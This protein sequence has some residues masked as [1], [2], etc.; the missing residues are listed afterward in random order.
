[1]R[2]QFKVRHPRLQPLH[3]EA[4]AL[5][6]RLGRV[7]FE[8]V[9]RAANSEADRL[10]NAAMDGARSPRQAPAGG[11]ARGVIAIGVDIESNSNGSANCSNATARASSNASS[12]PAKRRTACAD[13]I[14]R[15]TLPP[16]SPRRRAAMKAPGDRA[17][18]RRSLAQHRGRA[19]RRP[20]AAPA[21]RRGRTALR[22]AGRSRRAG[23]D[24]PLR[25]YRAGAGAAPRP[26]TSTPVV[27]RGPRTTTPA[28]T[29]RHRR[30][31]SLGRSAGSAATRRHPATEHRLLVSAVDGGRRP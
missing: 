10:A 24:E 18:R 30:R 1:M 19:G 7:R 14:P 21:A 29:A 11:A 9:P 6:S 27:A 17:R 16:A 4:G 2:G 13:G 23:H 15:S 25:R 22:C 3:R 31:A 8:H 28:R 20:A 26:L 12:P 5:V